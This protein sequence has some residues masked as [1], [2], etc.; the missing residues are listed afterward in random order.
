MTEALQLWKNGK[1]VYA[2]AKMT[3]VPIQ[4]LRDHSL[5]KINENTTNS[6]PPSKIGIAN[7]KNLAKHIAEMAT[8]GYGYSKTDVCELGTDFHN[9]L[10]PKNQLK[11]PLGRTWVDGFLKRNNTLSLKKPRSL[12]MIRA[13]S[14]S[15]DVLTKY[16]D[17]LETILI[18]YNLMDSPHLIFNLDE[19]GINTEHDPPPVFTAAT[20]TPQSITSPRTSTTTIITCVSATG[21]ILPPFFIFKGKRFSENLMSGALPGSGCDM[22]PSGWSNVW[23]T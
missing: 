20:S 4:T 1:S 9:Y 16:Y 12:A 11:K 7:E 5:G 10:Y 2:A 15:A 6:G 23:R 22:S 21:Q 14:C 17:Q 19:T 8:Y 13:K 18:K 3:G